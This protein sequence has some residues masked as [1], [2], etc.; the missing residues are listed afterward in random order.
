MEE[1]LALGRNKYFMNNEKTRSRN[2]KLKLK[3][4]RRQRLATTRLRQFCRLI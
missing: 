1:R 4:R 2:A 3:K